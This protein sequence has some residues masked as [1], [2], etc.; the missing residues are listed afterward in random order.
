MKKIV[1][2]FVLLG[3]LSNS[4]SAQIKKD[5][6]RQQQQK[7]YEQK[8]KEAEAQAAAKIKRGQLGL[9]ELQEL[10]DFQDISSVDKMLS[11]RGW[12]LFSTTVEEI[13]DD[14]IETAEFAFELN[15]YSKRAKYWLVW[16]HSQFYKD[17]SLVIFRFSDEEIATKLDKSLLSNGYVKESSA[18]NEDNSIT[19]TYKNS[20]YQVTVSKEIDEDYENIYSIS[21]INFQR[22]EERK[23][24]EE[25]ERQNEINRMKES[26]FSL[27]EIMQ[28]L[29]NHDK[30]GVEDFFRT[31]GLSSEQ[32]WEISSL[33]DLGAGIKIDS[34]LQKSQS[35]IFTA[36]YDFQNLHSVDFEEMN[37]LDMG[38]PYIIFSSNSSEDNAFYLTGINDIS[39][40]KIYKELSKYEFSLLTK[41]SLQVFAKSDGMKSGISDNVEYIEIYQNQK[42]RI[43]IRCCYSEEYGLIYSLLVYNHNEAEERKVENER[44]EKE[45]AE[46]LR[47]ENK[48]IDAISQAEVYHKNGDLDKSMQS[49]ELAM[50]IKPENKSDLLL[51][52]SDIKNEKA[53]NAIVSK[54]DSLY[55]MK[56]YL[57]AKEFYS[58]ALSI[59]PNPKSEYIY[60]KINDISSIQAF[61]E[62]R[63]TKWYDYKEISQEDYIKKND[64]LI[65]EL[66][67][68]MLGLKANL[69]L[70]N[71]EIQYLIDTLNKTSVQINLPEQE[72]QL[73]KFLKKITSKIHFSQSVIFDYPVN[74]KCDFVFDISY[75]YADMVVKKT[76]LGVFS[77]H[78]EF[79]CYRSNVLSQLDESAPCAYYY[80]QMN[81]LFINQ[82][83]VE[84]TK[85]VKTKVYGGPAN[86][87]LSL[88]VPGLGDH[89]VSYGKNKGVGVALSTYLFAGTGVGGLLYNKYYP[90]NKYKSYINYASYGCF[91]VAGIVWFSDII[92]VMAKGSQNKKAVKQYKNSHFTAY[93]EPTNDEKGVSYLLSF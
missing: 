51:K 93:Y 34:L 11:S 9:L 85:I 33:Q 87:W 43:Y 81:Q 73:S 37:F 16:Q 84:N 20:K 78:P 38:F 8:K 2:I 30:N 63:L 76:P 42:Y 21:I 47:L 22:I 32:S 5:V 71:F 90:N 1:V 41:D 52:I 60:S 83:S 74:S 54:A 18:I 77:K 24:K 67:S 82:L 6:Q 14:D 92:W 39:F 13:D 35:S 56:Q 66:K 62:E 15:S 75:R 26:C 68:Y 72:I 61:L 59:T 80:F 23:K 64:Y 12:I 57:Q 31:K 79:E 70:I 28:L 65:N 69:S 55:K 89:R 49:Y 29:T 25:L 53:V 48:Y 4:V 45:K 88:L 86:A 27:S 40:A 91:A 3:F 10:A 7:Q 36:R 44:K 46:Q 58:E 17:L 50:E 19:T